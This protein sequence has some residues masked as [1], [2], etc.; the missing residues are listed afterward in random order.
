MI[1]KF[2]FWNVGVE[3]KSSDF[4]FSNHFETFQNMIVAS[5]RL[6]EVTG[7]FP[8]SFVLNWGNLATCR[9]INIA[10]AISKNV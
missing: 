6:V 5:R 2:D 9:N 8:H 1:A 7:W 10:C 4:P 3:L